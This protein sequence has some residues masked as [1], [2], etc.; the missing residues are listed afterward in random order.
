[1]TGFFESFENSKRRHRVDQVGKPHE[2]TF[3]WLFNPEVGFRGWL[4]GPQQAGTP[5]FFWIQGKPG[6]GKSTLM[7]YAL[8]EKKTLEFLALANPGNWH[9]VPF[10][11]HDRGSSIQKSVTGLLQELLYR[12]VEEDEKLLAFIPSR[13]IDRL[14]KRNK[15]ATQVTML[16][17]RYGE[18]K[19]P[20]HVHQLSSSAETWSADDLQEALTAITGQVKSPLNVLFFI[21]ALDE[22][23]GNHGDLIRVIRNSF[24]PKAASVVN[25]KF[26]LASR[27]DPAFTNAFGLCPGLLV[28]QYTRDDVQWYAHQQIAS[29]ILLRDID[30]DMSELHK[31]IGEITQRANGVFI[32]VR[33]VIEELIERFI[34]GSTISQLRDI[35]SAVPEELKDLYQRSL[36][37]VKPKYA[38]ESYVMTQIVLCAAN[39]QTLKSLLVATDIALQRK[40]EPMSQ[41]TMERRL[42]SRCG[43]LL[44]ETSTSNEIQFLH[45]TVKTFF[46]NRHHATSMFRHPSDAPSEDGSYYMLKYCIYIATRL[47]SAELKG[48]SET[49]KYLFNYAAESSTAPNSEVWELLECLIQKP[50]RCAFFP[51]EVPNAIDDTRDGLQNFFLYNELKPIAQDASPYS[52]HR[53]YDLLSVTFQSG[54]LSYAQ[55]KLPH[56]LP[57]TPPRR[58]PLLLFALRSIFCDFQRPTTFLDTPKLVDWLLQKGADPNERCTMIGEER[59][60]FTFI[61]RERFYN[62]PPGACPPLYE[63]IEILLRGGADANVVVDVMEK[64]AEIASRELLL[65]NCLEIVRILLKY[66]ADCNQIDAEGY[67]PLYYAISSMHR[68]SVELLLQHGADP[69]DLGNGIDGLRPESWIQEDTRFSERAMNMQTLLREYWTKSEGGSR[70]NLIAAEDKHDLPEAQTS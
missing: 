15:S 12:L 18:G 6:S 10:F 35:L 19:G 37:R 52:R 16:S 24:I 3:N 69:S 59:T 55:Y 45:Q 13:L 62:L 58:Y 36:S 41:D 54:I 43:G 42:R 11:F 53:Y 25:V 51:W 21:D 50:R 28:H 66:G 2:G 22:H 9:L 65:D 39:P 64:I 5:I 38:L 47:P 26:C 20:D 7:K 29:S 33:I 14:L 57:R 63:A 46:T 32:W 61:L 23:E 4:S 31:L 1:M 27:P 17:Q 56:D 70:R 44:E 8:A 48:S 40:V 68:K 30:P 60:T 49:L 34:D 67:R